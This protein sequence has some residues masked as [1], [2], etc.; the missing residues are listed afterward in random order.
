M[1]DGYHY[2]H[3]HDMKFEG[4]TVFEK[5]ALTIKHECK[6]LEGTCPNFVRSK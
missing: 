5:S 2:D 6:N 3:D 4:K 1:P